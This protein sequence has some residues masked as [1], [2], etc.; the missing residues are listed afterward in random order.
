MVIQSQ[1][2]WLTWALR[3]MPRYLSE[4]SQDHAYHAGAI[5]KRRSRAIDADDRSIV[6]CQK[7]PPWA[8]Y[9]FWRQHQQSIEIW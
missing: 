2:L 5:S 7:T 8:C 9:P 6:R 3:P 4:S 1:L